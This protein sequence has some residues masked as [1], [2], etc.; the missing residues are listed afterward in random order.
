MADEE[1]YGVGELAEA[2][3]VSVRT[4]RYYIAEGLLPPA[5]TAGARSYY[6]REHLDRLRAIGRLKDAYLPLREIRRQLATL[7]D[8][9]IRQIADEALV[10]DAEMSEPAA[11]LGIAETFDRRNPDPSAPESSGFIYGRE[12][13]LPSPP[14]TGRLKSR[15]PSSASDYIARVL[16]SAPRRPSPAPSIKAIADSTST[17]EAEPVAWRRITIGDDAELLIREDAYQRRRDK[18]DWLIDW[19]RKVIE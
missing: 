9:T 12:D 16:G 10:E 19:A 11:M 2:A 6:S 17:P 1:R 13:I 4:V 18:V 3:D 8:E 15:R 14:E 7:D 5:V